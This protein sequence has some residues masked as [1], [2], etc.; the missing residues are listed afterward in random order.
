MEESKLTSKC[1]ICDQ[2]FNQYEFE[3]HFVECD[4]EHECETCH[5][6]F[7][8]ENLLENHRHLSIS[9]LDISS[10]TV[11]PKFFTLFISSLQIHPFFFIFSILSLQI[12]PNLFHPV[13]FIFTNS[14]P[15]FILHN[16]ILSTSSATFHIL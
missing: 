7:Q 4:Q 13:N 9:S 10:L 14:S 16:I 3:A 6:V 12:H 11:Y 2:E 8:T 15:F 1:Y 5:K